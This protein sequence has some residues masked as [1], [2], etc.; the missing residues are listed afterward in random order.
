M[1]DMGDDREVADAA[2]VHGN[3]ARMLAVMR[4]C[5]DSDTRRSAVMSSYSFEIL[6]LIVI[7]VPVAALCVAGARPPLPQL[8]VGR[9]RLER[10]DRRP[11]DRSR[12]SRLCCRGMSMPKAGRASGQQCPDLD[13]G[14][15][16]AMDAIAIGSVAVGAIA[17][18]SSFIAVRRGAATSGRLLAGIC[19]AALVPVIFV[20]LIVAAFCGYE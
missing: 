2:L 13:S 5:L 19:A 17:L 15:G 9:S 3:Q 7:G 12:S 20:R 16:H 14:Q 10:G 1:V 8:C 6:W 18:A 4:F 11:G